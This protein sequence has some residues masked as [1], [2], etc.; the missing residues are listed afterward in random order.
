MLIAGA[1]LVVIGLLMLLSLSGGA[2][3]LAG[4]WMFILGLLALAIAVVGVTNLA[5]L[6]A[7]GDSDVV[8][9]EWGLYLLTGGAVI[10]LFGVWLGIG[11][12]SRPKPEKQDTETV[13]RT[14]RVS[15]RASLRAA[16]V[17]D[18]LARP[19]RCLPDSVPGPCSYTE[20]CRRRH[21]RSVEA[22]MTTSPSLTSRRGLGGLAALAGGILVIASVFLP[23][24][25]YPAA[26]STVTGWDT[27]DL[28]SGAE[29]VVHPGRLRAPAGSA[30]AFSGVSVLIAGGVLV[31]IGLAMLAL[32]GRR[33]LPAVRLGRDPG[34]GAPGPAGL[35]GG[36][37]QPGLAV[38]HRRPRTG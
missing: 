5:S 31:L 35:P 19:A 21:R 23:W 2:F 14:L 25:G 13:E 10:G 3:R 37:H 7:T 34:P 1:L 26:G 8:S 11:G 17:G 20:P 9:P 36:R 12:R 32:A 28:A 18:V 4:F 6:L 30:P 16:E 24:L 27:Y 33:G 15:R 29:Q 22:C 38:R